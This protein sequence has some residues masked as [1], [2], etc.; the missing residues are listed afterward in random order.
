METN[1]RMT[2]MTALTVNITPRIEPAK[3]KGASSRSSRKMRVPTRP[4]ASSAS[5]MRLMTL[6]VSQ[7]RQHGD[8]GK[9]CGKPAPAQ[10]GVDRADQQA[11]DHSEEDR[12]EDRRAQAHSDEH[13]D[14]RSEDEK[15]PQEIRLARRGACVLWRLYFSHGDKRALQRGRII[16]S[17]A[18]RCARSEAGRRAHQRS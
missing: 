18:D 8:Q 7:P 5:P 14:R 13:D 4:E 6:R 11:H 3:P 15:H 2:I 1:R 12:I 10:P 9:R 17:R 16:R